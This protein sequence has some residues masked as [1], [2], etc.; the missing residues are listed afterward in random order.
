[1]QA[2]SSAA[3]SVCVVV[4]SEDYP[5]DPKIGKEITVL[6][7]ATVPGAIVFHAGTRREGEKYYTTGGR[8]LS[9]AASGDDLASASNIAY[10]AASRIKIDGARYRKDIGRPKVAGRAAGEPAKR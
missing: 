4:A 3:A 5:D 9:V 2:K 1:M 7:A 10:E 8:V 6:D